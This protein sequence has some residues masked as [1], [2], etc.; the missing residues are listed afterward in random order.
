MDALACRGNSQY[1]RYLMKS[2][3]NLFLANP[4]P[5]DTAVLVLDQSNTLSFAAATDP[6]RAAN[7]KAGRDLFRW[8][9]V[10]ANGVPA[11]LT[12]GL[13][14]SGQ[15]IAQLDA[16]DLLIIVAGFELIKH[17]TPRL[18]ASLRRLTKQGSGIIAIDGGPWLLAASGLLDG[19]VATTHWEDLEEFASRFPNVD[20]KPDRYCISPPFATSGGAS[21]AIDLMLQLIANRWGSELAQRTAGAFI[22]DPVPE[23]RW[24]SPSPLPRDPQRPK[25]ISQAIDIMSQ[26]IE[27]PLAITVIAEKVGQSPRRL[28][29]LFAQHLG[30]SPQTVYLQ[31]RLSEAHRLALDTP[32]R[33]QDIAI[34]TGFGSQAS[35]ARAFRHQFG[36]SVS[37]LRNRVS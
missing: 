15:D 8:K 1:E 12:T 22:Y 7:R 25:V 9:F 18:G 35:F 37:S 30:Q 5:L 21:P 32:M 26:N 20:V 29:Q 10:T 16:C 14:V 27:D 13:T 36:Q 34:A 6:M 28:Q 24:Q 23:G 17:A 11:K 2:E 19:H 4:K 31:L 3:T 33:S